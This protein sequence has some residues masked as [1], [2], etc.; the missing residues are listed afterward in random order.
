MRIHRDLQRRGRRSLDSHKRSSNPNVK[1]T[2][3]TGLVPIDGVVRV[4]GVIWALHDLCDGG[5]GRN[6]HVG[7]AGGAVNVEVAPATSEMD[8]GFPGT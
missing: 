1:S 3:T 6:E 5:V 8:G 7:E 2:N 4:G